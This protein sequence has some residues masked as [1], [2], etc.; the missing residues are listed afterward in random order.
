MRSRLTALLIAMGFALILAAP[1]QAASGTWDRAWGNDVVNGGGTGFEICTV[2]ATCQAGSLA[3]G[4]GGDLSVPWGVATD[5]A[6]DVYVADPFP[7]NRIQKFDSSGNFLRAWGTDVVLTGPDDT[8]GGGF[9]ICVAANGDVCKAAAANTGLGGDLRSPVGVAVDGAGDV[10]VADA[11]NHRIQKFTSSGAFLRTW[12]ED[13]VA[14]GPDNTGTG[15]E[16]CI[17]GTGDICQRAGEGGGAGAVAYPNGVAVDGAGNV[18]SADDENLRIDKFT[19]NGAFQRA[20]GKD[21]DTTGS[22]DNT[23][24]GFEICSPMDGDA[25]QAGDDTGGAGGEFASVRGVG[26]DGAGNVYAADDLN[27]RIQKFASDGTFE[28]T[29]GKDV[30]ATGAGSAGTGAEICVAG[31]NSCKAGASGAAAGE[32]NEPFGVASDNTGNVYVADRFNNRIG[33]FDTLGNFQRTW[34]EDVAAAGPGNTGTGFEICAPTAGDACKIG[35]QVGVSLGGELGLPPG[36]GTDAAG[37]V[38]VADADNNRIQK[39]A[40]PQPTGGGGGAPVPPSTAATGR[41][42][43]ALKKCKKKH[44]RARAKCKKKAKKLPV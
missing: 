30:S 37:D 41:R 38:Y 27:N 2:A 1:A 35:T 7:H 14:S 40:D 24:T 28:R 20:W 25:C 4:E 32:L 36:V 29:W 8:V 13:V 18:Y 3:A 5:A 6:G 17:S 21:V 12:G 22:P 26:T 31:V 43:A 10:Y 44:R 15:A 39:F 42:A 16:I 9:E 11:D 19:S 33:K 34:G 23:G